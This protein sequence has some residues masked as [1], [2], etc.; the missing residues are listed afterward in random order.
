MSEAEGPRALESRIGVRRKAKDASNLGECTLAF[1]GPLQQKFGLSP[2]VDE[3]RVILAAHIA[4]LAHLYSLLI[5]L[6][7]RYAASAYG[8]FVVNGRKLS[9]VAAEH[10]E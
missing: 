8:V 2:L 10:P 5:L 9:S 4:D 6:G 1:S 3:E 7:F